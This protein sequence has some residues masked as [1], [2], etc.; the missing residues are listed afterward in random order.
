MALIE[1]VCLRLSQVLPSDF[2]EKEMYHSRIT[3]ILDA[4]HVPAL[5]S[6]LQ[7]NWT[8]F[9][10]RTQAQGTGGCIGK[11]HEYFFAR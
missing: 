1:R 8:Q 7:D 11:A 6:V 2:V 9:S 5:S 10:P 4:S 3:H